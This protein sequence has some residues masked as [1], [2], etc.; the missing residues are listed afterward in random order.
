MKYKHTEKVIQQEISIPK[1][2]VEI[3]KA[4][5]KA[6]KDLF[7]VGGVVRDFLQHKTPH[8]FDLVT[9]ALPEETKKIL[10]DW[11]VSDEQGANF[12]V[13][14]IYTDDEPAGHEIATY[15][16]DISKGRDNKGDDEKVEIGNH[17]K[18]EDDVLRRDLTINA[19]FYDINNKEIVDLVGGIED[20]KNNI[21]RT[22]GVPS[23]R[24]GEDRLKLLK[25]IIG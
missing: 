9:N 23:E 25:M 10:K 20:I 11:N 13:L 2:V 14:R 12:G 15:R 21:I 17:I 8:D 7:V 5:H 3:A 19:L 4:F 1:D 18:I 22:V 16:K 6:G 24:F